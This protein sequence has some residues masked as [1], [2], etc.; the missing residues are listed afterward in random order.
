LQQLIINRT[1]SGKIYNITGERVDPSMF[2]EVMEID[3]K[4]PTE[5][6]SGKIVP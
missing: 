3:A 2:K 1:G 6:L 5:S 4:N